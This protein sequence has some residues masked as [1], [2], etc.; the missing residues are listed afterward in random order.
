MG[1]SNSSSL[2]NEEEQRILV[3]QEECHDGRIPDDASDLQIS[4][5]LE[6]IYE[7]YS[8]GFVKVKEDDDD[9][10]DGETLH[11]PVVSVSKN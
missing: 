9:D 2:K 11:W 1:N 4:I 7:F 5:D 6:M 8:V 10:D 3:K